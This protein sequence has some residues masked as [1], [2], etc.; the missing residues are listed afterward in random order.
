MTSTESADLALMLGP[1]L[2]AT[3]AKY[4]GYRD[5][6]LDAIRPHLNSFDIGD[7]DMALLDLRVEQRPV[8]GAEAVRHSPLTFGHSIA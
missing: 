7:V 1:R 6:A 3:R 8:L 4:H 5:G 2:H